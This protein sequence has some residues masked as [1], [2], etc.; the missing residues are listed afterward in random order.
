MAIIRSQTLVQNQLHTSVR[1]L[2]LNRCNLEDVDASHLWS[3][4]CA[5]LHVLRL[6]S[7]N[8]KRIPDEIRHLVSLQ[9]LDVAGNDLRWVSSRLFDNRLQRV[10]LEK[11]PKLVIPPRYVIA[12][13]PEAVKTFYKDLKVRKMILALTLCAKHSCACIC[14]DCSKAWRYVVLNWC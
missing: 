9:R 7:N 6:R 4:A 8:L 11:N 14:D 3:P 1:E 12:K 5:K 10:D 13:G 2:N